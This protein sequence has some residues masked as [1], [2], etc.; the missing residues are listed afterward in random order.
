MDSGSNNNYISDQVASSLIKLYKTDVYE[1]LIIGDGSKVQAQGYISFW[2]RC[3]DYNGEIISYILPNMHQQLILGILRLKQENPNIYWRLGQVSIG[4]NGQIF[5]P[6]RH[7]EQKDDTKAECLWAMC[8]AKAFHQEIQFQS[9]AFM[10][11]LRLVKSEDMESQSGEDSSSDIQNI[12]RED[13]PN[14]IWQVC[15]EFAAVF[16]K[17]IPKRVPPKRMEHE[18]KIDLKPDTAPIHWPIYKLSPFEL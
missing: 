12:R 16:P 5:L 13:L 2:L 7:Q 15:H 14:N 10:G 6:Y 3:G 1:Q 11:I 8:S 18:L 4:Q 9:Q 17:D